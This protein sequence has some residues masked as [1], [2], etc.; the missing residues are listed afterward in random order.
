ME[1]PTASAYRIDNL[2]KR[3]ERI[4]RD[5]AAA[6]TKAMNRLLFVACAS[7]IIAVAIHIFLW[8]R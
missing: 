6:K 7:W 4:E 3:I 5:Q 8:I 2:E 1:Y